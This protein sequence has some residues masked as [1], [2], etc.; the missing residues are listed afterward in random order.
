M[1]MTIEGYCIDVV[2]KNVK[3]LNLRVRKDGSLAMSV[4]R[5]TSDASIRAF[6]RS[7]EAWIE[8]AQQRTIQRATTHRDIDDYTEA[9]RAELK[10]RIAQ[11]LSYIEA[12]TGL[13]SNGW[14]VR[15]M[16]TR[17]GSC[18]T[19]T[20]HLNFSIMLADEPDRL[21]DYVIVHELVHT[22]VSDHG[23]NFKAYMDRLMPDWRQR[24]RELK[25]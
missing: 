19:R 18:N 10:A 3:R 24:Q 4:P 12:Q 17:W 22:K 8:K 2:R 16:H 20:H 7:N 23:P 5:F 21:L 11:R 9:D 13:R 1:I 6:V 14:T 15:K 25:K